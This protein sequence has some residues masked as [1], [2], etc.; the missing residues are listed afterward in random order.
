MQIGNT[1]KCFKNTDAVDLLHVA[2][3]LVFFK[4]P[5][6]ILMSNQG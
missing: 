6:V 1:C 3:E 5:W 2:Q 4:I